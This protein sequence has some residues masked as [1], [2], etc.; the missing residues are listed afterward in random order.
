MIRIKV[1]DSP[2]NLIHRLII[3]SP[4]INLPSSIKNVNYRTM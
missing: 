1:L 3:G 4:K 2:D